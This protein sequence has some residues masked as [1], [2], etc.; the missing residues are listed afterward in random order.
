MHRECDKSINTV[1]N[2]Q[3]EGL[4]YIFRYPLQHVFTSLHVDRGFS[5]IPLGYGLQPRS[6]LNFYYS[7]SDLKNFPSHCSSV[8]ILAVSHFTLQVCQNSTCWAAKYHKNKYSHRRCRT[9]HALTDSA[10]QDR[11]RS[12]SFSTS[13]LEEVTSAAASPLD[14]SWL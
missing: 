9:S 14:I 3:T 7:L 5:V 6:D 10:W 12:R 1:V 4:F 2:V 8:H 11:I 13:A